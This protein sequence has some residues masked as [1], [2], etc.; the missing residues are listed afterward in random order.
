MAQSAERRQLT[1]SN[2]WQSQQSDV[3]SPSVTYG[4]VSRARQLTFSN[5]WQSQQSE[6]THL[7]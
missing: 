1:F 3:N 7:Q 6:T 4:T 2:M 5:R